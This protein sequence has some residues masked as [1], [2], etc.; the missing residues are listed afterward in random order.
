MLFAPF[1]VEMGLFHYSQ[2]SMGLLNWIAD[3]LFMQ[4]NYT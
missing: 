4:P 3:V 2:W 1:M